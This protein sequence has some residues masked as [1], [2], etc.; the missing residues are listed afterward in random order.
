MA[1][2]YENLGWTT[3]AEAEAA[4]E[5]ARKAGHSSVDTTDGGFASYWFVTDETGDFYLAPADSDPEQH[6]ESDEA[7]LSRVPGYV[8]VAL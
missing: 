8:W 6:D 4:A 3:Q 2:S 7:G 1:Y 5:A